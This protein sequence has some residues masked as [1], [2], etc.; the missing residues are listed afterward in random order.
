MA[1]IAVHRLGIV[2]YERAY[3]LQHDLQQQ[4]IDDRCKGA[5]VI[6]EHPPT[7]TIGKDGT[8]ANVLVPP[9]ELARRGVALFFADR[10][11]DVTYHG[12]GQLVAYPIMNVGEPG[13]RRFVHDLEETI[14]QTLAAF[15][16]TGER[17]PSNAGIWVG[18]EEIAAIGIGLRRRVTRHGLALNVNTDLAAFDLINPCGFGDRKATSM[19]AR[20]DRAVPMN[21]VIDCFL[22]R[23][24]AVFGV[25]SGG[26]KSNGPASLVA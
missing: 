1:T 13:P 7:V 14:I 25:E 22:E 4:V 19:A 20:L 8:L 24:K 15:S 12:P 17:D 5:L 18:G 3:H 10:G 9:P 11:G 6:L 2:P 23:F 21:E 26:V 16:I